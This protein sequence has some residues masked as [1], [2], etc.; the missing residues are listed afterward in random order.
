[1]KIKEC[2]TLIVAIWSTVILPASATININS[3]SDNNDDSSRTLASYSMTAGQLFSE[4]MTTDK[5]TDRAKSVAVNSATNEIQNWLSAAGNAKVKLD[6]DSHFSLKN[7]EFDLLH[8]WYESNSSLF[9]SQHSL[10]RTDR[11]LQ[12]NHGIGL[13]QFGAEW[14]TGGNLFFDHDLSHYHS[15]LGVGAELWRDYLKLGANGYFRTSGWRSAPELDHDY[16][17]RP[18]NGWDL[19]ADGWIP[20]Y[21]HLGASIKVEKYYGND[22]A[23]MGQ[24]KRQQNPHAITAG[25]NWTPAPLLTIG[26]EHRRGRENASESRLGL[27][28]SWIP[29]MSLTQHLDP[30]AVA[31]RRTVAGSRYDHV[32]RN[33]NI[34]LEYQKKELV[35]LA[36]HEAIEGHSGETFPLVMSVKSKYPLKEIRWDAAEFLAAGGKISGSDIH[37][38]ITLPPSSSAPNRWLISASAVDTKD[39]HSPRV[40]TLIT[41][42]DSGA[43][44]AEGD[45]VIT[46][47]AAANGVASNRV[48]ATVRGGTGNPLAGH[49]VTFA[50]AQTLSV[51]QGH[52]IQTTTNENGQVA[53]EV[54]SLTAGKHELSVTPENGSPVSAFMQFVGDDS[55]AQI[56]HED[57]KVTKDNALANGRDENRLRITVKD[58]NGNSLAGQLVTLSASQG[59][60]LPAT[61]TTDESGEAMVAVTSLTAGKTTISVI[62]DNG[63]RREVAV[64]F[65]TDEGSAQ[66]ADEDF[67]VV[68]DGALAN[69]TDENQLKVVV[70]DAGGNPLAGQ[71][72][73]LQTKD[74]ILGPPSFD[75][76]TGADGAVVVPVYSVSSGQKTMTASINDSKQQVKITFV[77]NSETATIAG[78]E[79]VQNH[80]AAN[81]STAN[82]VKVT[83]VDDLGNPLAGQSVALEADNQAVIDAF[84][85]SDEEGSAIAT[86]TSKVAGVTNITA[87]IN[88][89]DNKKVQVVFEPDVNT[90][91]VRQ[92]INDTMG[93]VANGVDTHIVHV[94]VRDDSGNPVAGQ[95]VAMKINEAVLSASEAVT[96]E[97]G[98]V[99]ISITSLRS[100]EFPFTASLNGYGNTIPISFMPDSSTAKIMSFTVTENGAL[101]NGVNQ[102]RVKA[103]VTDNNGNPIP[104]HE[105]RFSSGQ[106]M[107]AASSAI[108]GS[109]G[110]VE[111][112]ITSTRAI[113]GNVSAAITGESLN[114]DVVFYVDESAAQYL[115]MTVKQDNALADGNT[116]NE[117]NLSLKDKW[118]NAIND[119]SF[120]LKASNDAT[121][122][123]ENVKTDSE[124]NA[125]VRV[126]SVHSGVITVTADF[127]DLT[128]AK[129]LT[130]KGQLKQIV[131]NGHAFPLDVGFPKTYFAGGQFNVELSAGQPTIMTGRIITRM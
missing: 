41:V 5:L 22:V 56:A 45:L 4:G 65:L 50:L 7:A 68:K 3:G 102:N 72:V 116:I 120:I 73:R 71:T 119:R 83:I 117:L 30:S 27:Q 24:D 16:N 100:G 128:V 90:A 70:K 130:F 103:I 118:G 75:V 46:H 13:R 88:G 49:S 48:I 107:V 32:E 47:G 99:T 85:V 76:L 96:G 35:T 34:V 123:N 6:V 91:Y 23:L 74:E 26:A 86:L 104:G 20:A 58:A 131:A 9:F 127:A 109:D 42:I 19:R 129:D 10:H 12:T 92:I 106:F 54:T 21:P 37:T 8:P 40:Q 77:A 15:R 114:R 97:D 125:T 38:R 53:L 84:V 25:V 69:G 29:G 105:V 52:S 61:V 93:I 28:L 31:E 101:A 111:M 64:T 17:A 126:R 11:R 57:I 81:G 60:T 80:A 108:T 66:I 121:I 122:V 98:S 112:A 79:V 82:S 43:Q 110:S 124:G 59:A 55:S 39:N 78:L 18:A 113:I 95:T 94:F 36:L 44:I 87:S 62:L 89:S 67:T 51:A 115:E 2:L 33:N 63:S 1:M 14:M